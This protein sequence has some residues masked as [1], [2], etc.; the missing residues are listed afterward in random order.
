MSRYEDVAAERRLRFSSGVLY[1]KTTNIFQ[2]KI[3]WTY[4]LAYHCFCA[5]ERSYYLYEN[6]GPYNNIEIQHTTYIYRYTD[7]QT[8]RRKYKTQNTK[9]KQTQQQKQTNTKNKRK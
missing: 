2:A 5:G 3:A 6:K 7:T 1:K 9:T 8:E 4:L